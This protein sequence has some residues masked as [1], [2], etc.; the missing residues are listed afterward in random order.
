MAILRLA[1]WLARRARGFDVMY[2]NSQKSMV[3]AAFA[4]LL[5]RR[6]VIWHLHDLLT[7]EH[8]GPDQIRVA[9]GVARRLVH[10]VIANSGATRDAYVAAGGDARQVRVIYNGIDPAPFDAVSDDSA[11]A[12]RVEVGAAGAPLVGLFGRLAPWKGHLVLL[13]ALV[14]LPGVHALLVGGALFEGDRQYPEVVRSRVSALGLEDRVHETGFRADVPVLM[15]AC[16]VI[17][18]ASTAAEPFGRVIVEGML[19]GRP[20][21]ATAAGGARELIEDGVTGV[22][23]P[24]RDAPALAEA[25]RGLLSDPAR[26]QTMAEAGRRVARARYSPARIRAS[27]EEAITEFAAGL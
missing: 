20:V 7:D 27:V 19:A 3:V 16:D 25:L 1:T 9:V 4:G 17:V 18:H 15:R 12:F 11:D 21:V 26:A 14:D 24:P 23:V 13:D 5:S 2:A 10:L 8:F 22:L 6:P